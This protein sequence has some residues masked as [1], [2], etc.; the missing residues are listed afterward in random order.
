MPEH[1][2]IFHYARMTGSI[3]IR[4]CQNKVRSGNL[5]NDAFLSPGRESL[6]T[7]SDDFQFETRDLLELGGLY[8]DSGWRLR[9]SQTNSTAS[10]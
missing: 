4:Q 5:L 3:V 10:G 8:F 7:R 9:K 1:T 2:S 6:T